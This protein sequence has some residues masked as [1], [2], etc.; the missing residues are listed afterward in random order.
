MTIPFA[1]CI[2]LYNP[3]KG[4]I[5]NILRAAEISMHLYVVDNSM[6]QN[7][8][9]LRSIQDL[10]SISYIN[11]GKN[12]GIAAALNIA[13][14]R[15]IKDGYSYL[16]TLDQDSYVLDDMAAE[17]LQYEGIDCAAIISPTYL[18]TTDHLEYAGPRFEPI[19]V[20]KTSGSIMNLAIFSEVGGFVDKLFI[21]FVDIEYCLRA[22]KHGYV[23]I[24][25]NHAYLRHQIGNLT[26]HSFAGKKFFTLNYPPIRY[27]YQ[28]RNLCYVCS[29]YFFPFKRQCSR[30][31][32]TFIKTFSKILFIE[33]S[34]GMKI[35]HIVK[36]FRDF[37]LSRYN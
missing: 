12:I 31:I 8:E 5:K 2:V 17:M 14:R 34:K 20:S 27:Y 9:V 22:R 16:M 33:K 26:P 1:T 18:E 29:R 3:D 36:G 11:N 30:E 15:A 6:K 32:I 25:A 19:E 7:Q 21:D 13:A 28:T 35:L 4:I 37:L 23:I 24:R 10:E